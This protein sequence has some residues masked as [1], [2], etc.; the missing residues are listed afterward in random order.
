MKIE[1]LCDKMEYAETVTKWIF[2]EFINGVKHGQSYERILSEV[3]EC[4]KHELP[5]RLI[6][7]AEDKCAGTVSLVFN[8]LNCRQYTPWLAA[9]YV[10][11][12]YRNCGV[13]EQLV[14]AV[15]EITQQLGYDKLYLRTETAS[16]YY[17]KLG[18]TFVENCDDDHNLKPDV[19]SY[20]I[21]K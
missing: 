4:N 2:D 13:G 6:A 18:W 12:A 19:F 10:D 1:Y 21:A 8:D 14:S 5:I 15:I 3:S 9:L 20:S 17:R 7:L 16:D 11:S